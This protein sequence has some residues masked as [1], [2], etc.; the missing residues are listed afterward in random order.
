MSRLENTDATSLPAR[1]H[2]RGA[3][4]MSPQRI[5]QLQSPL[6]SPFQRLDAR[7]QGSPGSLMGQS[8]TVSDGTPIPQKLE[9]ENMARLDLE[10][11]GIV[12]P[13]LPKSNSSN[14]SLSKVE[15]V[16]PSENDFE[17]DI[18]RG[19]AFALSCG[20][21]NV[22]LDW[23]C[24][25]LRLTD[26]KQLRQLRLT[27]GASRSLSLPLYDLQQEAV[28]VIRRL[29]GQGVPRAQYMQA[30]LL[31]FGKSG[32]S[33]DRRE[34]FRIYREASKGGFARAD[35]RIGMQFEKT[36]DMPKACENYERGAS[37]D[38]GAC[39]YRLGMLMLLGQHGYS[40]DEQKAI[41]CIHLSALSADSDAPQGAFV[42]A[43]MLAGEATFKLTPGAV[44]R[45][46]EESVVFFEKAAYLGFSPAQVRLGKA[47]EFNEL[48]CE[49]SPAKSVHYYTLAALGDAAEGD[50]ALSKWLL[51]G[52]EDGSIIK[53]E[54]KSFQHAELAARRGLASAE[55][56]LGYFYEIGVGCE[57]D[58]QRAQGYYRQAADHGSEEARSRIDGLARSET[59]S[60]KDHEFNVSTQI[61][62]RQAT[63]K[64]KQK[65]VNAYRNRARSNVPMPQKLDSRDIIEDNPTRSHLESSTAAVELPTHSEYRSEMNSNMS[66]NSR[67]KQ[68]EVEALEVG[69]PRKAGD[70]AQDLSKRDLQQQDRSQIDGSQTSQANQ[71]TTGL[72][73]LSNSPMARHDHRRAQSSVPQAPRWSLSDTNTGSPLVHSR[74]RSLRNIALNA[75]TDRA[76]TEQSQIH[77]WNQQNAAHAY[78]GSPDLAP[79]ELGSTYEMPYL[80]S[81]RPESSVSNIPPF[82]LP[83]PQ[84]DMR[85][86]SA[87]ASVASQAT[88]PL[89]TASSAV[90][91]SSNT[92]ISGLSHRRTATTF[93]EMGIPVVNKKKE[94]CVMM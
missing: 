46:V 54:K 77:A 48:D 41:S 23:A 59:M 88:G 20:Q 89:S 34:A 62:A 71:S 12:E 92:S 3:R 4:S 52:S 66:T 31:E 90:A 16:V 25:V 94:D 35:Y 85:P 11:H 50:M 21:T 18:R 38:D 69:N 87:T 19:R 81:P 73:S 36:G 7:R 76:E 15:V 70:Y 63:I 65:Q 58:L 91:P 57:A 30:L 43:L 49:F 32:S 17:G 37:R 53:D 75:N 84:S 72:N 28:E 26:R 67:S 10:P 79:S 56:A 82:G 9:H 24:D 8:S 13:T 60:R 2:I 74:E 40:V 22:E 27:E 29:C 33:M 80:S 51:A 64:L 5:D 55:F 14:A 83:Q 68:S 44:K 61:H 86:F 6:G 1:R 42:W 93:E 39:L 45:N 47:H 78:H